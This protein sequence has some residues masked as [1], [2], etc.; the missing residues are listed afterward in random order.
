VCV[1]VHVFLGVGGG[2]QGRR[3]QVDDM[4]GCVCLLNKRRTP[5]Q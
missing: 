1:C 2:L 4:C 3:Q 5:K